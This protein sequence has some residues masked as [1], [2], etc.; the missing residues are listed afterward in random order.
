MP[1]PQAV[2]D[3]GLSFACDGGSGLVGATS[4]VVTV[5]PAPGPLVGSNVI[6][7]AYTNV[8]QSASLA[9]KALSCNY[10]VTSGVVFDVSVASSVPSNGVLASLWLVSQARAQGV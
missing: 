1:L 7:I 4:A 3:T 8:T 10:S 6:N 9:G 2:T 5:S